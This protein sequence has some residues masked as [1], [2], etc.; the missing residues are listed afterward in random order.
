M[1]Q[2]PI[3]VVVENRRQR[4]GCGTALAV[5]LLI[6][7]AIEYWYVALAI[8][9]LVVAA[10]AIAHAKEKERARH[11][12]GPQDPWLNEIA[13]A[14]ADL[15]LTEYAR[16]TGTRLGGAPLLADIGLR[17]GAFTVWINLLASD[18]LARQA[19]V[20]LRAQANVRAATADG[21]T[22]V[23]TSGRVVFVARRSGGVVDDA[24]LD[25]IVR[26]VDKLAIVP[27]RQPPAVSPP[28]APARDPAADAPSAADADVLDQLRRLGMLHATGVLTEAEFVAKKTELL[29]RL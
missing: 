23:R 3:R 14:L 18:E 11:A 7:L 12:P 16:N 26:T 9:V 13:V 27:P 17:D 25:D 19:E 15:D 22:A 28:S 24:R 20:G 8:A 4:G 21:R 5:V 6:G 29:R 2:A 1:A 10:A